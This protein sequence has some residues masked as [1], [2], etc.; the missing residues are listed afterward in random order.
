MW[1]I[2]SRNGNGCTSYTTLKMYNVSETNNIV[3]AAD[4]AS[5][6]FE[7]VAGLR[8][9]AAENTEYTKNVCQLKRTTY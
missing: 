7:K 4:A 9:I 6:T 1:N 8:L 5:Q 3:T 2:S